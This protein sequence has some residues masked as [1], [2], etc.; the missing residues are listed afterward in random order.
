MASSGSFS[1]SIHSGHYVLRVDWSQSQN[2]SDNTSTITCKLYL[3]NDWSL[4]I[5]GRT[6]NTCSIDGTSHAFSSAAISSKGTHL[7]DTVTQTVAHSSDGSKSLSISAV[8]NIRATLSGTYYSSITASATITL[9]S[10]PRASSFGTISGTVIGS[11]CSVTISR[12]STA[13]THQLWYKVGSSGW[14]DLGTGIETSKSF[15]IA[16][17][18]CSQYPN[19]TSGTMQLCVRTYNGST[20]IGSDVYKSVTVTIPDSVKPTIGSLSAT[21]VDGDV[22]STWGIYVQAKSKATVTIGSAAGSYGST[23][24]SYS[25]SGGGYSSTASSLTTGFLNSSGTVKFTAT[26][27]DS[28]GRTSSAVTVSITVV[29]YAAPSFTSYSSQRCTSGGTLSDEG[30]YIKGTVKYTYS[31]CSS[32]NSVTRATYYRAVGTST[33]TNASK[34]F[35]SDTAFTFGG[36]IFTETSYEIKYTLT[37]AF[38]TISVIDVVSTASVVMDFKS[39]GKGVAIGKV[40]E[41]DNCFEV[42]SGWSAKF[43]GK[44]Y[45][46]TS[47]LGS[48]TRPIY[49]SGGVPTACSGSVGSASTPVYMSR[50]T[51]KACTPSSIVGAVCADYVVQK[52]T[53]GIWTYRKWN[54][55]YAECWGTYSATGV[56]LVVAHYSGFYYSSGIAVNLPFTFA[57]IPVGVYS[58]GCASYITFVTPSGRPTTTH[59]KF[60]ICCLDSGATSCSV[61][62]DMVIHGR[63]K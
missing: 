46:G 4:S 20:Q 17:E 26:V 25:I 37:D 41:T 12:A 14:Y 50:G 16:M 18:T 63:W 40:A 22:P 39:G 62:V 28:R 27:T 57:A 52:G 48:T 32:K 55:G 1:G 5:S 8:F 51:M 30:T 42:A 7:L 21:R 33:W 13:F 6:D 45:L 44:T 38:T 56:S 54:S 36:S 24:K 61:N 15:T 9:D 11:T 43:N 35:T 23:I 2:I 59:A 60:W 34:S 47:T 10:I 58:G 53:S 3:V 49:L 31:S 29:T 19:A